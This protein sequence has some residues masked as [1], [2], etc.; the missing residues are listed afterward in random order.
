M[1][2]GNNP[3]K[4]TDPDGHC[5]PV[6]TAVIGAAIGA[7]A[8]A[9]AYT[10]YNQG[11]SFNAGEFWTAVG[12][13]AVAGGLVG[14]GVGLLAATSTTVAVASTAGSLISAGTA[15][16]V[17]GGTYIANN[18]EKFESKPFV[19][20]TGISATTAYFTSNPGYSGLAKLGI[21]IAAAEYTYAFNTPESKRNLTDEL[22]VGAG[23]LASHGTSELLGKFMP[24]VKESYTGP[25]NLGNNVFPGLGVGNNLLGVAATQRVYE[26]IA[27]GFTGFTNGIITG[28]TNSKAREIS[29]RWLDQ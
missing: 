3:C 26:G 29:R 2:V 15:A 6:C 5:F 22:V 16:T 13:G 14:T 4:N 20:N 25:G 28:Y 23:A 1:Y 11:Q 10:A 12:V 8:G 21:R 9:V 7:I 17:T 27:R 18:P 19:V 24:A